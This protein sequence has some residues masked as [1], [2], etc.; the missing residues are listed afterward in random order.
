MGCKI[1]VFL[2]YYDI[3]GN[4]ETLMEVMKGTSILTSLPGITVAL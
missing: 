1:L 2:I 3:M 4:C